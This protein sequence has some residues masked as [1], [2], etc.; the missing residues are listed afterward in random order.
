MPTFKLPNQSMVEKTS[1]KSPH[2]A[3]PIAP[4]TTAAKK[5]ASAKVT[6]ASVPKSSQAKSTPVSI[7]SQPAL[8]PVEPVMSTP[9]VQQLPSSPE[10][11]QPK[12]IPNVNPD[13]TIGM[14]EKESGGD[15]QNPPAMGEPNEPAKISKLP[16][17]DPFNGPAIQAA[18]RYLQAK[19]KA[20]PKEFNP[21]QY[22]IEISGNNGTIKSVSPQGEAA[23]S[24]LQKTGIIKAGERLISPTASGNADWKIRAILQPDGNVDAFV[25]P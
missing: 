17:T 15:R 19:W 6:I 1:S 2:R 25:E 18:K 7:K 22:V 10:P 13:P 9:E 23:Q 8:V 20:D 14:G 16:T 12:T 11:T 21:L 5:P 4:K 24:Y 3:K